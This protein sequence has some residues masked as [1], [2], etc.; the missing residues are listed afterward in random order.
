MK[1]KQRTCKS[2]HEYKWT[3]IAT[4]IEIVRFDITVFKFHISLRYYLNVTEQPKIAGRTA[5]MNRV[6]TG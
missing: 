4:R 2:M 6:I 1:I 5:D 3:S